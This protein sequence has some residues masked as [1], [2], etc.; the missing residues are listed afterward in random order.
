MKK[1]THGIYAAGICVPLAVHKNKEQNY[2]L[3]CFVLFS[4]NLSVK[5]RTHAHRNFGSNEIPPSQLS[6]SF[7]LSSPDSERTTMNGV[8]LILSSLTPLQPN[9]I[10]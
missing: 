3:K 7:F 1:T 5:R 8:R 10:G 9:P 2:K 4:R 6:E